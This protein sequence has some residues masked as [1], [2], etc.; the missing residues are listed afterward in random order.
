MSPYDVDA[1]KKKVFHVL[2]SSVRFTCSLYLVVLSFLSLSLSLSFSL[3][4]T[5]YLLRTLD[6]TTFISIVENTG[7]RNDPHGGRSMRGQEVV[8]AV[9][10]ALAI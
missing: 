7:A 6:S 1:T 3:S 2:L 10:S 9:H 5:N 8:S 4:L